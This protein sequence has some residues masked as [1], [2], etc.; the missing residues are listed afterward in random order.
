MKVHGI[1][2]ESP[3]A[4]T[5]IELLSVI[6]IITILA[7]ILIPVLGSAQE[8]GRRAIC[9]SNLRQ[10]GAGCVSYATDHDGKFPHM[11]RSQYDCGCNIKHTGAIEKWG[12]L[13]PTYVNSLDV[14]FCP[15][16]RT[17]RRYAMDPNS[18]SG[19]SGFSLSQFVECSYGQVSGL[20]AQPIRISAIT[21]LSKKVLGID[22][23]W[24]DNA[25]GGAS[26]CHGGGYHN[27]VYFDGHVRPF[28]DRTGY[29]ETLDIGGGRGYLLPDGFT[30][31]E[32]NDSE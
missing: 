29:L 31:V 15:S 17:G 8:R 6:A 24:S 25:P 4:F 19:K 10:C 18:S 30:Y 28:V 16:R 12:L 9:I 5:L 13:Y 1:T 3:P 2:R 26:T 22:V 20:E 11:I 21:N 23:F 27:A 7:A 14:F 32:A